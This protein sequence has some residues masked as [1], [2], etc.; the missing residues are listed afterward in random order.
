MAVHYPLITLSQVA[1][2][3]SLTDEGS[4]AEVLVVDPQS[5]LEGMGVGRGLLAAH[6]APKVLAQLA[7][8]VRVEDA[9]ILEL[10]QPGGAGL[11]LRTTD[12]YQFARW[13]SAT[14]LRERTR[15]RLE[16]FKK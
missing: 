7:A 1:C 13:K 16:E 10:G 5:H 12:S 8:Q 2:G 6:D 9:A 11:E 15:T 14:Y 3:A 4:S